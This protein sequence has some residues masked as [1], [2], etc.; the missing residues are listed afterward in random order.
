MP[1]RDH[2]RVILDIDPSAAPITGVAEGAD[3]M[4]RTFRGWTA[5]A[6]AVAAALGGDENRP[7][8]R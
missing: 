2:I 4:S 6:D 1:D 8:V 3:G 5:L 7:A